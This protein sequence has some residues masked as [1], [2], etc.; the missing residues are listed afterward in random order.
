MPRSPPM[1]IQ[2][3]MMFAARNAKRHRHA[4]GHEE[5]L[6]AAEQ[7]RERFVPFHYS[8]IPASPVC[9]VRSFPKTNRE[10]S[11]AISPKLTG[12]EIVSSQR[13]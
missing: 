7:D 9:S 5:R 8:C 10:N 1:K 4:D 12:K 3:P 11:I 13:G 2:A 6:H